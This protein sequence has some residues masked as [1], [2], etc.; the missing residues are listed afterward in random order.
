M[1]SDAPTSP[2]DAPTSS[3]AST[4]PRNVIPPRGCVLVR[5]DAKQD[6]TKT[7]LHLPQGSETWPPYGTVVRLG[8]PAR[9][10]FGREIP[11]ELTVG[12][13]VL[14]AR[15][16]ASAL[17]PDSREG[18]SEFSDLLVLREDRD[19]IGIVTEDNS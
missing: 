2:P 13:R 19:I 7:G 15:R 10:K 12:D 16:A 3:D 6:Q 8:S 9:D 1:E 14:F 18:D 4:S 5:Q 17:H 11:F